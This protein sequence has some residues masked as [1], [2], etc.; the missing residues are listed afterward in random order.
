M[1]IFQVAQLQKGERKH[2]LLARQKKFHLW[3]SQFKVQLM[4]FH[5]NPHMVLQKLK[6]AH[7]NSSN[8]DQL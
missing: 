3:Y 7:N 4:R 5:E 1:H 8:T 2:L 6:L